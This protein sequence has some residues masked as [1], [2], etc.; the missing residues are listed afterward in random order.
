MDQ[1][2]SDETEDMEG[3]EDM[4]SLDD[5]IGR[6]ESYI[7]DPKLVTP[8]TLTQLRDELIEYRDAVEGEEEEVTPMQM[9]EVMRGAKE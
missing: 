8:E 4:G 5:I 3:M 7:S 2:N 9:R 6:I 1:M